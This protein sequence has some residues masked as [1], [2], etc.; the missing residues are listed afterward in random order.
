[1]IVLDTIVLSEVMR[2]QPDLYAGQSFWDFHVI[3]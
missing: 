3:R 2:P 1:M